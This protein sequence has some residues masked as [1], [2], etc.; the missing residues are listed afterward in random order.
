MRRAYFIGSLIIL[1]VIL[2]GANGCTI[3]KSNSTTDGG[4]FASTDFGE[5]WKQRVY[6]SQDKKATRTIAGVGTIKMLFDPVDHNTIYLLTQGNGVYVTSNLG[7]QWAQTSLSSGT[8]TDITIDYRNP[9]VVYTTQGT[10]ILKSVD[11]AKTWH[12]IYVETRPGQKIIG[13]QVNPAQSNIVY[14]ATTT[15]FIRSTDYGTTWKLLDWSDKPPIQQLVATEPRPGT[16]Y[17]LTTNGIYKSIDGADTWEII[18]DPLKEYKGALKILWMT[19]DPKNDTIILGTSY[20]IF[21]S[22]DGGSVW[23]EIPTLYD[24]SKVPIVTVVDHPNNGNHI[25]FAV[26]NVLL[27]TDDGGVTWK[28]LKTVPTSR[29]INF[30]LNDPDTPDTIYLGTNLP[31]QS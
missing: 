10:Q 7:A 29:T 6:V 18:T 4:F 23:N 15:G 21:R 3:K 2:M 27:K 11:G 30:L 13:V 24:F 28:T 5:N 31:P 20:G 8:Y 1:T 12:N 17:A 16:L 22:S 9:K 26:Q 25:I 19:I 14:A